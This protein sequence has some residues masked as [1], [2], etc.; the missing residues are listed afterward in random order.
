M[1]LARSA[2]RR[3][4]TPRRD[5]VAPKVVGRL[6]PPPLTSTTSGMALAQLHTLALL[7][8]HL[9]LLVQL[10]MQVGDTGRMH[11]RVKDKETSTSWRFPAETMELF[12]STR[13][14]VS[15]MQPS[16]SMCI[17]DSHRATSIVHAVHTCPA[18]GSRS[19]TCTLS[20]DLLLLLRSRQALCGRRE[21]S[22]AVLPSPQVVL[23]GG[24]GGGDGHAGPSFS[25]SPVSVSGPRTT[26]VSVA[27]PL[28]RDRSQGLVSGS[29]GRLLRGL[30]ARSPAH[31]Q[32]GLA[33]LGG[34]TSS[35][36][37]PRLTHR[38]TTPST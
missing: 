13:R 29:Y 28:G 14:Y 15:P 5:D 3:G 31:W 9:P 25:A 24:R 35:P 20:R 26:A 19:M 30:L 6:P 4:A 22:D 18:R 36:C 34:D 32:G 16:C 38:P 17:R 1:L 12:T 27:L 2:P 23:T 10:R 7:R 21:P 33:R 8:L 11:V 37:M